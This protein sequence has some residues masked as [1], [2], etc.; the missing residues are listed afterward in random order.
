VAVWRLLTQKCGGQRGPDQKGTHAVVRG[1]NRALSLAVLGRGIR[2]RHAQLDTS[3]EEEG[4]R[5]LIV[6]LTPVVTLDD[7]NGE[8][9][10]S[11]HPGKE[12]EEGGK[13][14]RLGTQRK[15]P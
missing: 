8:G 15:S 13:R 1:P 7:L 10:L 9:E 5:G 3:R 11:R 14:V 2:T 4:T 12:V 6:E